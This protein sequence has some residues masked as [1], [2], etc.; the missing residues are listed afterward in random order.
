MTLTEIEVTS[1]GPVTWIHLNRPEQMNALTT[2]MVGELTQALDAAARD[3]AVGVVVLSGRGRAFCAGADLK[4][5]PSQEA[6]R[7]R[8]RTFF[9]V[10]DDFAQLL[11]DF[12]K[13]LLASVSG[14]CCAGGLEIALA[15][16]VTFASDKARIGDV[17]SNFGLL[18]GLGGSVRLARAVGPQRARFLMFS[19]DMI[20][21]AEAA[22]W[23]LVAKVF[24][25]A[26]LDD[27]VQA[28]AERLSAKSRAGLLRMRQLVADGFELP[29][30]PA[31]R[32]ERVVYREYYQRPEL[33]EGQAAFREK[34]TPDF[35]QFWT[36]D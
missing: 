4:E 5:V 1:R 7:G 33:A 12:P 18:P 36:H 30:E 21:A 20:S 26:V 31:L 8:G 9:D 28:F 17:H 19:G 34:R 32:N 10:S 16:D 2:C 29:L 14:Y 3:T 22:E 35:R 6:V 25:A 15:A 13:P 27:E 24:E 23:G 11:T